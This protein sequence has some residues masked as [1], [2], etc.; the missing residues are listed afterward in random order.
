M[1]KDEALK[2]ARATFPDYKLRWTDC[3]G[4]FDGRDST[5]DV[6]GVEPKNQRDFVR[7]AR[8][9]QEQFKVG[10]GSRCLFIFRSIPLPEELK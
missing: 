10:L 3:Q 4:D 7:R 9:I 6:F 8:D 5:F 1:T 2:I